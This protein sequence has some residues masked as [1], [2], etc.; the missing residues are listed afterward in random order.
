MTSA[1]ARSAAVG[2]GSLLS[3]AGRRAR[4]AVFTYHQVL[5]RR[6]PLR[7]DEPDRNEF[8]ADLDVI[9]RV[10]TPLALPDAIARLAAGTLPARAACITFDDGYANNHEIAAP[11]LEAAGLP[12]TFFVACGAV[13]DGVMWNDLLIEAVAR[14]GRAPVLDALPGL[15]MKQVSELRGAALVR[16]LLG[17]MKYRPLEQRL[18]AAQRF[19]SD[20]VG[21]LAP[22]LMMSRTQVADLARRGFDMGGHTVRHPILKGL[23]DDAAKAEIE[24]C[25][26]WLADVTGRRPLTFA[27]PN[28]RPG[29]DFAPQHAAMVAAAGYATAVSTEWRLAR[30]GTDPYSVPRIGPWWRNGRSLPGVLAR[31]QLRSYW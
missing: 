8:A 10:F 12:A 4:L 3:P 2:I 20:N 28:G 19:Y 6:D 23:S 7:P 1:L 9:A 5:E 27:Y 18:A 13:D 25:S 31:M 17:G 29:V 16:A 11:L 30:A 22:R 21:E 15:D 14:S 24:S 26:A